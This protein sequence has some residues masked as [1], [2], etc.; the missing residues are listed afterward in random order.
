MLAGASGATA[1]SRSTSRS[2]RSSNAPS[3]SPG[4]HSISRFARRSV[5]NAGRAAALVAAGVVPRLPPLERRERV[6]V[7]VALFVSL[8]TRVL[9]VG[10]AVAAAFILFGLLIVDRTLPAEW[11]GEEPHVLLSVSL[12]G[13]EII[14]SEAL[15]R[16]ATTLGAFASLY[17]TGVALVIRSRKSI[18]S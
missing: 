13:R 6:N 5:S 3:P 16:V 18:A 17:C 1:N 14:V 12:S 7:A 9:A 8:A 11:V 4:R 2:I 10:L 15:V